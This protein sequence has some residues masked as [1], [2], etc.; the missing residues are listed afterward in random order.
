MR[1]LLLLFVERG[2]GGF[3]LLKGRQLAW[4]ERGVGS[5][6]ALK[7]HAQ[8]ILSLEERLL[9]LGLGPLD[10]VRIGHGANGN[11]LERGHDH[12]RVF[13]ALGERGLAERAE[14]RERV[15]RARL[16]AHVLS[17]ALLLLFEANAEGA[18]DGVAEPLAAAAARRAALE[19]VLGSEEAVAEPAAR[20]AVAAYIGEAV[21]VVAV[22]R[23]ERHLLDR[24]VH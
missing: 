20:G 12:L 15:V 14:P 5:G 7:R 21:L 16:H 17:L 3:L 4:P 10:G 18:A 1:L 6:G 24:L 13:E 8:R 19:R 22:R 23:A 9:G 2:G 11:G